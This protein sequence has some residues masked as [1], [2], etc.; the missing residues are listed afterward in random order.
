[1]STSSRISLA[2]RVSNVNRNSLFGVEPA[3]LKVLKRNE[4]IGVD[5]ITGAI[6][7]YYFRVWYPYI[8]AS[9]AILFYIFG[10]IFYNNVAGFL[11]CGAILSIMHCSI[12]ILSYKLIV[13]WRKHPSPLLLYRAATHLVFS[14]VIVL[15]VIDSIN[16]KD[17]TD[18]SRK[19]LALSFFT[20]FTFF[21]GECWLLTIAVDLWLSLTNPFTFYK[22]NIQKYHVIVWSS[23]ILSGGLLVRSNTCHGVFNHGICWMKISSS[24]SY[25]FWGFYLGW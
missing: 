24:E 16:N 2:K 4:I 6:Y 7:W 15:N 21:A 20:Q 1:M 3:I 9:S 8:A 10:L 23:G 17:V 18:D 11:L 12:V 5:K 22:S 19:C 13:P 25:C 14:I